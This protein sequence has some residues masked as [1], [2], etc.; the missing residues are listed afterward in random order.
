MRIYHSVKKECPAYFW[1]N[2]LGS[3][4]TQITTHQS[5]ARL[6]GSMCWLECTENGGRQNVVVVLPLIC[7]CV[8][9]LSAREQEN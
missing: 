8:T 5:Y 6:F 4:F 2:F 7:S 9:K 1:L 3:K